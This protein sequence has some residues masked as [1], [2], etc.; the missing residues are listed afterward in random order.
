MTTR[1]SATRYHDI[2]CGHRVYGHES[3]CAHPHG[4]NSR[5]YF[6]VEADA[7]D[8]VGRVLD[9]SVIKSR[10]CMWIEE[11]W[12]HKFLVSHLDPL[13]NVLIGIDHRGT[14]VV[15][16]NPTAELMAH[17][18]GEVV[19]PDVLAGTG[20]TLEVVEVW[21]TRKCAATWRRRRA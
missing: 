7:L 5:I 8:M 15:P 17:H 10:L 20:C 4:H 19:G 12:D 6:T 3:K 2:S 18:L 11:Q 16:F 1:I 9:F 13:Q 21:E 14:V